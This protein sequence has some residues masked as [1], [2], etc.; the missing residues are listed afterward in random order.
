M[1]NNLS[2]KAFTALGMG[3]IFILLIIAVSLVTGAVTTLAWNYTMPVV[4]GLPSI[5][6]L[7]GVAL[8]ILAGTFFKS[9]R[10]NLKD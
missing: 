3:M 9:E 6:Y 4:F 5:G 8:N 1:E 10:I 7:D 2:E